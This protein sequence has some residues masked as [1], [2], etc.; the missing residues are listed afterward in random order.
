MLTR[1]DQA[2]TGSFDIDDYLRYRERGQTR[3]N[4]D[5]LIA[6][7]HPRLSAPLSTSYAI[8][9]AGR[10]SFDVAVG[11]VTNW[12]IC[13]FPASSSSVVSPIFHQKCT[14]SRTAVVTPGIRQ[15]NVPWVSSLLA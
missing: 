7:T 6:R 10:L 14:S 3:M 9:G 2:L 15:M 8:A 5:M 4:A 11:C 13:M 12:R 1:S